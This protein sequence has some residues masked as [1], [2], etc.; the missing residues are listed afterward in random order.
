MTRRYYNEN[1]PYRAEWLQNLIDAG[2][3]P[4]GDLDVR[5]I[6]DV[7]ADDL[8]GYDEVHLFA[9]IGGL[10][11]A[12]R[13]ADWPT[14]IPL[15]TAGFCCQPHSRSGLQRGDED[16]RYLW[17]EIVRLIATTGKRP[18]WCLF[19]NVIG[20]ED[21][22]I[23]RVLFDLE[24][25]G[26]AA[27]PFRIPACAVDAPHERKRIAIPAMLVA[28]PYCGRQPNGPSIFKSADAFSSSP[29]GVR[30]AIRENEQKR[31]GDFWSPSKRQ[32]F[33][34]GVHRRIKPGLC[35]MA[36]GLPGQMDQIRAIGETVVP[37][38]M[39]PILRT[40][41]VFTEHQRRM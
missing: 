22:A 24:N 25:Y 26:Y 39:A 5:S 12:A 18:P 15:W 40:M 34:N 11:L 41:K 13:M 29:N 30:D 9:G 6:R 31:F 32:A 2:E 21:M 14:G 7:V 4:P 16:H 1:N 17:P 20:I 36:Y 38:A 23:D 3:L 28:D 19:E 37:Q 35:T 8:A 10:A 33:G 27:R